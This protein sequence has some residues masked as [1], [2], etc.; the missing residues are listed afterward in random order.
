MDR[1]Q[2]V[3]LNDSQKKT[4]QSSGNRVARRLSD[5][6]QDQEEHEEHEDNIDDFIEASEE[7]VESV[8]Q[9]LLEFDFD[10]DDQES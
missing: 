2:R 9:V 7:E 1:L 10:Y 8:V 4:D 6:N 5:Q 3:S